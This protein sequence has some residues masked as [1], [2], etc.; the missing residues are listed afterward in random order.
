M[1]DK[2][3]RLLTNI[4]NFAILVLNGL[5]AMLNKDT[6]ELAYNYISNVLA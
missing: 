4:I 1:E 3:K 2:T 5:L 6:I